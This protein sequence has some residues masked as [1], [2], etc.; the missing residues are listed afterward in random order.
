MAKS[1][2]LFFVLISVFYSIELVNAE[3]FAHNP[4][5]LIHHKIVHNVKREILQKRQQSCQTILNDYPMDCNFTLL[6][7]C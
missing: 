7:G 5:K 3:I 1:L 6:V 4:V 2:C